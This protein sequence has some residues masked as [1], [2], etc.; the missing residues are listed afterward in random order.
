MAEADNKYANGKI[1]ELVYKDKRYIGSTTMKLEHRYS[2]HKCDS[3]TMGSTCTSKVLFELANKDG[4]TVVINLLEDYPCESRKEL[5]ARERFHIEQCQDRV[6]KTIPGRSD[7][8]WYQANR[9]RL[10]KY[11]HDNKEMFAKRD[12]EKHQAHRAERLVQ[13]I[14]YRLANKDKISAQQAVK[15]KCECGVTHRRNDKARHER[16]RHHIDFKLRDTTP[17]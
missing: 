12:A 15:I 3:S 9:D 17:N 7:A 4:G 5:E 6:N 8:E 1:Y 11:R 14:E 16:S 13:M 2:C 10:I